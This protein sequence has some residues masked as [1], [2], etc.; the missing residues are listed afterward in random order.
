[1]GTVDELQGCTALD[2][3]LARQAA[4]SA[5]GMRALLARFAELAQPG[6]GAPKIFIALA[7]LPGQ[8]WVEGRLRVDISGDEEATTIEIQQEMGVGIVERLLPA[9]RLNVPFDEFVRAIDLAP[10]LILPLRATDLAGKIILTPLATGETVG[11]AAP[12]FE[13]DDASLGDGE[14]RTQPPAPPSGTFLAVDANV[15]PLVSDPP[16]ELPVDQRPTPLVEGQQIEEAL[17][18]A[19]PT[20]VVPPDVQSIREARPRVDPR[21]EP[22]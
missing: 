6:T 12:A 18:D 13:L 22:D 17:V 5:A 21:R 16:A 14:R 9:T 1:V 19:R 10:E 2:T 3:E 8:E 4:A 20:P 7:R 15:R 11:A